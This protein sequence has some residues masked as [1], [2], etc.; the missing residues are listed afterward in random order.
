MKKLALLVGGVGATVAMAVIGA[1]NASANPP[2]VMGETYG[3]AV[4]IL[5]SQGYNAV[6]GGSVGSGLPQSQ[7]IVIDQQAGQTQWGQTGG[8]M[9]LRLDCTLKPGET[10]PPAPNTHSVV[11]PGGSVPGATGGSGGTRPTPGAGTVTVTPVPVG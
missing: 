11:P 6:C 10:A 5:K 8:T 2:D 9:R 4:S 7:C 3:R 1:G